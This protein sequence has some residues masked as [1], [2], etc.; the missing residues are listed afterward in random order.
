M[1]FAIIIKKKAKS[2]LVPLISQPPSPQAH[3]KTFLLF[4]TMG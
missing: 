1:C 2:F 3:E 4:I